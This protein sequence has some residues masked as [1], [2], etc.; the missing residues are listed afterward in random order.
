[1]PD[2]GRLTNLSRFFDQLVEDAGLE[3]LLV[4]CALECAET[5]ALHQLEHSIAN[6]LSDLKA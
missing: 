4:H 2:A 6:Q 1:M 5:L 3:F